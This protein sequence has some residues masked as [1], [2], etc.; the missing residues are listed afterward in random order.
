M[1]Q[2]RGCDKSAGT[3]EC[4]AAGLQHRLVR[5]ARRTVAVRRPRLLLNH[6][7]NCRPLLSSLH[8]LTACCNTGE[9]KKL[10]ERC[11]GPP[12]CPLF[13]CCCSGGKREKERRGEEARARK[14]KRSCL[15]SHPTTLTTTI[16]WPIFSACLQ[17]H[18]LSEQS[19]CA[20]QQQQAERRGRPRRDRP[21]SGEHQDKKKKKKKRRL[22]QGLQTHACTH[23][24]HTAFRHLP[25]FHI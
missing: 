2:D 17:G 21:A 13:C 11:A 9:Q 3:S 14:K 15:L 18:T 5:V 7:F 6:R 8:F 1:S 20:E 10:V 12:R 23:N 25:T 24:T 16:C 22:L 19:C 4:D